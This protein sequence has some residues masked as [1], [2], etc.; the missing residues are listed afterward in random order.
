MRC[1]VCGHTDSKVV[2]SRPAHD[3]TQVRRRRE[4]LACQARFT[5]Y[6]VL[7]VTPLS[8]I[9][10]DGRR[11]EFSREK[12]LSGLR[13]AAEKRPV[14]VD[15]LERL[16]DSINA[17]LANSMVREIPFQVIGEMV[18]ERLLEIDKIAYVRFASVYK[19]FKDPRDFL[20]E[21]DHLFSLQG[22]DVA[23]HR[24]R[25]APPDA[26]DGAIREEEP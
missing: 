13:R 14:A 7:E 6:E 18:L 17:E 20:Q 22:K 4:C 3:F 2:D 16:V 15:V 10:K 5:T 11:E 9:K 8:V 1:H 25:L 26:P 12:L 23:R 24:R 21:I 19:D